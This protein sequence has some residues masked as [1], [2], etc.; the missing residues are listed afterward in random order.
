MPNSNIPN[1]NEIQP[2]VFNVPKSVNNIIPQPKKP[3]WFDDYK[4]FKPEE[5][6]LVFYKN[7]PTS[8]TTI[9]LDL[10]RSGV[11]L[12]RII[13]TLATNPNIMLYIDTTY[14]KGSY[15]NF[16]DK[17]VESLVRYLE[18]EGIHNA[19]NRIRVNYSQNVG[20]DYFK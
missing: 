2:I 4:T 20:R 14:S 13:N 5:G 3:S 9:D 7:N 15:N 11:D 12:G 8:Q 10:R 19:K 6:V 17:Q 1:L 16:H 18:S